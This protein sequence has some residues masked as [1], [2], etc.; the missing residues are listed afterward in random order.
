MIAHI[1]RREWLEQRRQP[2]ML[3]VIGS[4][5]GIVAA[6]VLVAVGALDFVGAEPDRLAVFVQLGGVDDPRASIDALAGSADGIFTFLVFT[7]FLEPVFRAVAAFVEGLDQ[8]TRFLPGAA[9]DALVGASVFTSLPGSGS[10][11]PLEW[12]AGGLVLLGYALVLLVVGHLV[13]WRRDVG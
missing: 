9:G 12:W 11:E 2:A 8:V 5:Y 1:A 10:A 3:A 4:L 13:S 6:L 7:Q